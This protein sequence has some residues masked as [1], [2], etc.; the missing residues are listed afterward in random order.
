MQLSLIGVDQLAKFPGS[1]AVSCQ[2]IL[3]V[4]IHE[5]SAWVATKH[6]VGTGLRMCICIGIGMCIH[7]YIHVRASGCERA[8]ARA[9][10][11][12]RL[13]VL[14]GSRVRVAHSFICVG[15]HVV[16]LSCVREGTCRE[17]DS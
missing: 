10:L 16:M 13:C 14:G 7:V 2:V 17:S 3:Q 6:H 8:R 4:Y 1:S 15:V 12:V 5:M 11:C 9:R